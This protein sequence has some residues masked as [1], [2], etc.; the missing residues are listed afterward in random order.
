MNEGLPEDFATGGALILE[1]LTVATCDAA[2]PPQCLVCRRAPDF[3]TGPSFD[4]LVDENS[5]ESMQAVADALAATDVPE[6]G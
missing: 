1:L 5:Q 3:S 6:F 4:Q 2:A